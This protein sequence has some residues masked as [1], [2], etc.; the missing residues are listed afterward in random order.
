MATWTKAE[1]ATAALRRLL[2]VGAGQTASSEDLATAEQFADGLFAELRHR[3]LAV[4]PVTA[5]PEWAQTAMCTLL[6]WRMAP[7]YGIGGERLLMLKA[8]ADQAMRDLITQIAKRK[9]R[10]RVV[11]R[12]F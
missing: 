8:G 1:W 12:Y 5:I 3:R 11:P 4:F 10:S 2:I 6:S 7:E 9:P